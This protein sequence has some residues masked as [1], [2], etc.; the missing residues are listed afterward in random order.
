MSR[1]TQTSKPSA[2]ARPEWARIQ[3]WASGHVV[4]ILDA[5]E[6]RYNGSELTGEYLAWHRAVCT[7]G[8]AGQEHR[9]GF[10]EA[11]LAEG[12]EHEAQ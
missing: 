5:Y 3:L 2:N 4:T 8:W 11:A 1:R 9:A 10:A 6:G 12:A 7:C